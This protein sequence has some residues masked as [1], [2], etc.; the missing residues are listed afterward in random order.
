MRL[1][2]T[3]ITAS[4]LAAQHPGDPG[5]PEHTKAADLVKQLGHP[6]FTAREAAAKQL[7]EMGGAA[8]AALRGGQKSADE[9][10]RTRCAILLPRAQ[11][12]GWQRKAEAFLADTDGK[13]THQLPLLPEFET[14]V[15]GAVKD[16]AVRTLFAEM[17][18]TNGEFLSAVAADRK[19]AP[20]LVLAHGRALLDQTR[21][22]T[23]P[24][25][26]Q[27]ADLAAVLFAD[28]CRGDRTAAGPNPADELIGNPGLAEVLD[29]KGTG[30][31]MR[32]LLAYWADAG[33]DRR[34]TPDLQAFVDLAGR[35]PFPEAVP[36][37]A[38]TATDTGSHGMTARVPAIQALA[39]IDTKEARA[40]LAGLLEEDTQVFNFD[41]KICLLGDSALAAAATQR[42]LALKEFGLSGPFE[43]GFANR[44]GQ[45][46]QIRMVTFYG[47]D[48][49]ADRAKALRKW[50]EVVAGKK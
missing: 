6:R 4:S 38:R 35:K 16:P 25:K 37:L 10:V 32:R 2:F 50:K 48:T 13:Q 29:D 36:A 28:A 12:E 27:P 18:R 45:V 8:G 47:F 49:A 46:V 7:V 33:R 43:I 3:L 17:A 26:A 11:A 9:E 30:P 23:E 5:T 21:A 14:A 39:K 42:G 31:P 20:A 34:R 44:V 24:L 41:G 15:G 19:A 22:G 1:L 40:T